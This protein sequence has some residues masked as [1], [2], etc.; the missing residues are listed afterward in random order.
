MARRWRRVRGALLRVAFHRL[1]AGV[2]G[3]VLMVPAVVLNVA[4]YGW[5]SWVTEG[6]SLVL[7]ATGLALLLAPWIGRRPDWISDED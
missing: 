2:V 1:A 3:L 5:E 4:D 6:F 7:A